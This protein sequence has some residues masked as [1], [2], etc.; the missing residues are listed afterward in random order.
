MLSGCCRLHLPLVR[1]CTIPGCQYSL[2][3]CQDH[4]L[5]HPKSN[6]H[7]PPACK[8][9]DMG[10]HSCCLPF[11]G[12][13]TALG[14]RITS[15][16]NKDMWPFC[17]STCGSDVLNV[18]TWAQGLKRSMGSPHHLMVEHS[19]DETADPK[20]HCQGPSLCKRFCFTVFKPQQKAPHQHRASS[21]A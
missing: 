2:G 4:A 17:L 7:P 10:R 18:W 8:H 21:P 16:E 5:P 3:K 9:T 13:H 14:K 20:E 12:A 11:Q 15:F 19:S 6:P 1:C